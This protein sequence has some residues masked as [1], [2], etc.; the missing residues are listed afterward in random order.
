MNPLQAYWEC[1]DAFASTYRDPFSWLAI[2]GTESDELLSGD[3]EELRQYA[4][5]LSALTPYRL[6]EGGQRALFR[7]AATHS[8]LSGADWLA[9]IRKALVLN[10]EYPV[11]SRYNIQCTQP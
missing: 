2:S 5:G 3:S 9:E 4:D 7:Q 8:S 6:P 10:T 11:F 1:R